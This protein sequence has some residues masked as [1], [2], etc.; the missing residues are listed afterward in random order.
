MNGLPVQEGGDG[1]ETGDVETLALLGGRVE[2]TL[3]RVGE[4]WSDPVWDAPAGRLDGA[5][6]EALGRL[7]GALLTM[8]ASDL[9][10]RVEDRLIE[11]SVTLT[12]DA[13][14]RE[15]N[16]EW[17]DKDRPTNVLSFPAEAIDPDDPETIDDVLDLLPAEA[18]LM[19][20]DVVVAAETV[21]AE[22]ARQG[23]VSRAHLMHL[24]AHGL[25]HLLGHD[26]VE[27]DQAERMEAIEIRCLAGFD[28]ADP[29]AEIEGA[30]DSD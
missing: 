26:H 20:G 2:V 10:E 6:S 14:V 19:L 7:A 15:L 16:R 25:L 5:L 23:K 1:D 30:P 24:V 11:I 22:A 27:D 9:L 21:R 29:Y 3:Q 4:I 8:A 18:P 13:A 17:R 12:D 28:I